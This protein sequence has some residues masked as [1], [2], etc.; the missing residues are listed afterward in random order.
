ML[1]YVKCDIE[2]ARIIRASSLTEIYIWVDA[3]YAVTSDMKSQTDGTMLMG[4]G[5]LCCKSGKQK[6]NVKIL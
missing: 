5:V 2:D 3:V 1:A 4:H 6:I